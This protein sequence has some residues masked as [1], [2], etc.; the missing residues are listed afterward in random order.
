MNEIKIRPAKIEDAERLLEIYSYYIKETAVT[1]EWDVLT[2]ESFA[3]RIRKITSKFPYLVCE[4]ENGKIQG[5]VYASSFSERKAY[6]WTV[7]TSIYLDKDARRM[8]AGSAL[9][10]AL[11]T[12]L[13][14]MDIVNLIAKIAWCEKEDEYLTHDSVLFHTKA[15]YEYSGTLKS[16]GKKFGRWYDIVMMTKRIAPL[17]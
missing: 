1:Y 14:K 12:E 6:D 7:E 11:E 3:D 8:G 2:V 15:G 4:D 10:E 16:V 13:K 9:Y 17:D 5:F